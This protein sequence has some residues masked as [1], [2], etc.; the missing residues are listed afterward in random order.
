MFLILFLLQILHNHL[1]YLIN[2]YLR[3]KVCAFSIHHCLV[4]DIDFEIE[5]NISRYPLRVI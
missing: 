2:H 1:N 4:S 3:M 5:N